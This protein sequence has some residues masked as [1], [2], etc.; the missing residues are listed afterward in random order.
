MP[1]EAKIRDEVRR[2]LP[3]YLC[4]ND[5]LYKRLYDHTWLKCLFDEEAKQAMHEVDESFYG[6]HQSSPK[7]ARKLRLMGY[8]WP[9]LILY[10]INWAQG[11]HQCHSHGDFIHQHPWPFYPTVWLGHLHLGELI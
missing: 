11:C 7:M 4:T 9:T 3:C 8:Y 6:S 5:T 10:F 1:N 2:W